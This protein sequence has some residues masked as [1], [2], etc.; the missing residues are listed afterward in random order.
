[1]KRAVDLRLSFGVAD[2][3]VKRKSESESLSY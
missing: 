3:T 2:K 1:M